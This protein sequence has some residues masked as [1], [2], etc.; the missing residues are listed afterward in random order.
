[1]VFSLF[2]LIISCFTG[3][4]KALEIWPVIGRDQSFSLVSSNSVT[5]SSTDFFSHSV[6]FLINWH[7]K[8]GD[9]FIII[10]LMLFLSV[11]Y[12][13]VILTLKLLTCNE[14]SNIF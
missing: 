6:T 2:Y 3:L 11:L 14:K 9:K 13:Y 5:F 4:S 12:N 1:M 8:T 10:L 7:L